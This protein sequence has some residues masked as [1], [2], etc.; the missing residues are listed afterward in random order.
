MTNLETVRAYVRGEYSYDDVTD[1]LTVVK[2]ARIE[3]PTLFEQWVGIQA[4]DYE[5]TDEVTRCVVRVEAGNV[6]VIWKNC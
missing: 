6:R 1:P 3:M 4:G 2:I 5:I